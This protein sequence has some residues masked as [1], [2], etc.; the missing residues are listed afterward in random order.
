LSRV[1]RLIAP[2][3]LAL[4]VVGLLGA[5]GAQGGGVVQV[6]EMKIAAAAVRAQ[7]SSLAPAHLVPDPP[8]FKQCV[9][10]LGSETPGAFRAQLEEECRSQYASLKHEA[11][12]SLIAVQ[13]LLGAASE[14][15][16]S[17]PD[18]SLP[19]KASAADRELRNAL[20]QAEPEVTQ[21]EAAAYYRRNIER[22]ERT[23]QRSIYMVEHVSSRR[24]AQALLD[25]AK[26][27]GGISGLQIQAPVEGLRELI[28]RSDPAK[29]VPTK[30]A[31]LRAIFAAMPH[32]IIGPVALNEQWCL[33]EVTHVTSRVVKPL[34]RVE[35]AIERQLTMER[36]QRALARFISAW[37]RRWIARTDC[38]SGYVVQKC[39][40]YRGPKTPEAPLA[41]E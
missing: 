41:F 2:I 27:R 13:W 8:Q 26:R 16:L 11:L 36:Q 12:N 7:M 9:A 5:C 37:R 6:G 33:F 19:V 3:L 24:E 25:K 35:Q 28:A 20:R 38:S 40:Q 15:G 17:L 30:R 14:R 39:K 32:T 34:A 1:G 22:Y 31:V 29:A 10:R 18:G 4:A 21:A 23:E